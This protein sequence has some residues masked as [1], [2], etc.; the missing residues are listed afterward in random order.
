M[1]TTEFSKI[2]DVV[3]R[4]IGEKN[5]P[6]TRSKIKNDIENV[7]NVNT[8]DSYIVKCDEENNSSDIVDDNSIVALVIRS[9]GHKEYKT[10]FRLNYR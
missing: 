9:D 8:A 10:E 4:Y 2:E 6:E 7:L 1:N 5:T 3:Y